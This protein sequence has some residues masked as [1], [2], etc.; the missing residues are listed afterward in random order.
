MIIDID[1]GNSCIKWRLRNEVSVIVSSKEE[2]QKSKCLSKLVEA[3]HN[4]TE[5][6]KQVNLASVCSEKKTTLIKETI[7]SEF[8][9]EPLILASTK[10]IG[11]IIN[12]Y[13]SPELMGVD[14]WAAILAATELLK[15]NHSYASCIVDAGTATTIDFICPDGKHEGG[16]ILPG[17]RL[18]IQSLNAGVN[19]ININEDGSDLDLLP[20]KSTEVAVK[21]GIILSTVSLIENSLNSYQS[22]YK[23]VPKLFITGGNG[24]LIN[25]N[26]S[27][28]GDYY[29][30][31]VLDGLAL[32]GNS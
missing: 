27:T 19:Q 24:L 9:L 6:V 3:A 14:R 4:C 31:L 8:N 2:H 22:R 28:M 20:G 18:Q 13:E 23:I 16:Y 25:K 21:N 5:K 15:S 32:L 26:L 12:S 29:P 7:R 11:D 17:F 1:A 10:K 30:D